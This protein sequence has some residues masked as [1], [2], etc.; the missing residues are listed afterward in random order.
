MSIIPSFQL[1]CT[2]AQLIW[3][4]HWIGLE[5]LPNLTF[6]LLNS[7]CVSQFMS[8]IPS[9]LQIC[10][11][12][13][14]IWTN[15]WIGLKKIPNLTFHLLNSLCVSQF[16]SNLPSFLQICTAA[17]LI[18]THYCNGPKRLPQFDLPYVKFPGLYLTA[19]LNSPLDWPWKTSPIWH[20]KCEIPWCVSQFYLNVSWFVQL[21]SWI[22]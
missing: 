10:T 7:W 6:H 2:A 15:H 17:Q 4:H 21:I 8:I 20:S 5:K 19:G 1:I 13:Q 3:T 12:A 9:F 11:A 14:L 18:W 16:V 22:V